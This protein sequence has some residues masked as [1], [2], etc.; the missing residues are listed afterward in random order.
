MSAEA[1]AVHRGGEGIA[2]A[3]GRLRGELAAFR[4]ELAAHG[5]PW[6]SD[7]VGSL[8]KGFYEAVHEVAMEC[9]HDNVAELGNRGQSATVM[10]VRY[11]QAEEA[12]VAGARLAG[13]LPARPGG[14]VSAW[15]AGGLPARPSGDL[16]AWPAGDL[17]A[18]RVR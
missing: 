9:F 18:W 12:G 6:G 10:A 17:P 3:A 2:S 16:P 4:A 11:V 5:E 14:D 13:D 15:P 1:G 8:I 7:D